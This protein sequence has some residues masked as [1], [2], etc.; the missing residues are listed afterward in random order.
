MNWRELYQ[1]VFRDYIAKDSILEQC[2]L[3]IPDT[4]EDIVST[5]SAEIALIATPT[6]AQFIQINEKFNGLRFSIKF[7]NTITENDK[8]KIG[9]VIQKAEHDIMTLENKDR[10]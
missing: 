8:Y 2:K 7:D 5:A 4:W 6:Q 9:Q 1:Q 10:S 3:Q